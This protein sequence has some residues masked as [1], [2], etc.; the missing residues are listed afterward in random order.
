[1]I[2][3]IGFFANAWLRQVCMDLWAWAEPIS[4]LY[5]RSFWYWLW[6]SSEVDL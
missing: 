5:G 6:Q 3:I 1:M 2:E 4:D